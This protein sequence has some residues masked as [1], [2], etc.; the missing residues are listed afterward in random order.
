MVLVIIWAPI[1]CVRSEQRVRLVSPGGPR[2]GEKAHLMPLIAESQGLQVYFWGVAFKGLY[3]TIGF[4]AEG[5][6]LR[7]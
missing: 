1:L 3:K 6:G 4:R 7:V 5:V 2:R